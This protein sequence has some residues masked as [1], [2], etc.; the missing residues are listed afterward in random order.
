MIRRVNPV[1]KAIAINRRQTSTR[2]VQDKRIKEKEKQANKEMKNAQ[3][4]QLRKDQ[5]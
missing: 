3:Q 2:V 1:A 4:Q 5:D